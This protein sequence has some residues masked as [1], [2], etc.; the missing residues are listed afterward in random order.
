MMEINLKC[1]NLRNYFLVLK[2]CLLKNVIYW[3]LIRGVQDRSHGESVNNQIWT[4]KL[5][6]PQ[7]FINYHSYFHCPLIS[8]LPKQNNIYLRCNKHQTEQNYIFKHSSNA[9]QCNFPIYISHDAF[10]IKKLV[11]CC[12]LRN[13]LTF[14]R[15]KGLLCCKSFL[16]TLKCIRA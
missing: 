7:N 9:M 3:S 16:I 15:K 10:F 1:N 4:F 6:H 14:W 5:K 12:W 13:D 8:I 11:M 2:R